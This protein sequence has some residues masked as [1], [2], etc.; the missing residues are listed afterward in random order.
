M[1]T[2]TRNGQPMDFGPFQTG[3]GDEVYSHPADNLINNSDEE[4]AAFG[5]VRH[6]DPPPTPAR[7]ELRKDVVTQRLIDIGKVDAVF[8]ALQASAAEFGLWF[9]PSSP[10]VYKDDARVIGMFKAVGLTDA[11]IAQVLA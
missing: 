3:G 2:F 5:I 4:L 9:A 11:E 6:P 7:A 8:G 1:P 10:N